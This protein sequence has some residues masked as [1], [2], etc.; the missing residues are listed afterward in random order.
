VV[1]LGGVGETTGTSAD[2]LA[3]EAGARSSDG[4]ASWGLHGSGADPGR[5]SL[6]QRPRLLGL[7]GLRAIAVTA[8]VLFHLDSRFLPGGFLGVDLFFVISGFLI[9]RLLL[10]DIVETGTLRLTRFYERRVR[11]LFPAVAVLLLVVI[12]GSAGPWRDELSTLCGG[13]VSS[14]GYVTNWWLVFRHESYFASTGR[15]PMLQH[16]WSLAIEEQ[17]YLL[18]PA[19]IMFLT[20]VLGRR[21][22][23]SLHNRLRAVLVVALL[24]SI[25]ST[26]AMAAMAV[27]GD[28][29]YVSD[30]SRV[31]FGSDTHSMGLLLGSAVGAWSVMHA[32][33]AARSAIPWLNDIVATVCLVMLLWE[34]AHLNEFNPGLYRGGF[35]VFDALAVL[36]VYLVSRPGNRT[37]WLLDRPVL[38][39]IGQRSYS[40]YLWHWPVVV[41]TRPDVDVHGPAILVNVARVGLIL[42]LAEASYRFVERPLRQRREGAPSGRS[43]EYTPLLFAGVTAVAVC[44]TLLAV[45][46]LPVFAPPSVQ[47]APTVQINRPPDPVPISPLISAFGDSVLLGSQ[48][49]FAAAEP[50]SRVNAIEGRQAH[51]VLDAVVAAHQQGQLGPVVVIHT[52][53]NGVIEPS[54]LASTLSALSDRQRIVLLTVRVSRGWQDTNNQTLSSVAARF[55]NVTLLDWHTLSGGHPDWL[56]S[57]GLHLRPEGASAYVNMV[58][59]AARP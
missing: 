3:A 51:A 32:E 49:A 19:V 15:P 37:G 28:V 26:A 2:A 23:R 17:Y 39:W 30:S 50:R 4:G 8:V 34:F 41:L 22:G 18:W 53:N 6:C 43:P 21:G 7:D 54:Q 36:V 55:P 11:R 5:G 59:T 25:A 12:A 13:V 58:I 35:F 20:G 46:T 24:L 45:V 48:S 42:I 31:Y 14:L 44:L 1:A 40:I 52:G 47:A 16:L 10:S 9:T 38:R 57:D 27:K 56:Y 29:P 33:L